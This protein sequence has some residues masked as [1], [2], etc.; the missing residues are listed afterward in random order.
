MVIPFVF[1]QFFKHLG[2]VGLPTRFGD[3][4][5]KIEAESFEE[6]EGK[7]GLNS[8]RVLFALEFHP[9]RSRTACRRRNQLVKIFILVFKIL[10]A[11]LGGQL[12]QLGQLGKQKSAIDLELKLHVLPRKCTLLARKSKE[13]P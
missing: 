8:T 10:S 5:S 9:G 7:P 3:C 6:T 4:Q 1:G 2:D 13:L 11:E 12:G